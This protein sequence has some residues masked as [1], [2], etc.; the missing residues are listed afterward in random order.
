MTLGFAVLIRGSIRQKYNDNH[1]VVRLISDSCGGQNKNSS[2]I[3]MIS[4]WLAHDAPQNIRIVELIFSIEGHSY[5]PP[6]RVFGRI[7]RILRM[8]DTI[9]LP[10]E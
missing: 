6:D 7:E 2:M 3:V 1:K 5:I 9:V 8:K 10:E 4:Y